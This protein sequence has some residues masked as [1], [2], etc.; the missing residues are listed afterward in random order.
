MPARSGGCWPTVSTAAIDTPW[1]R[2]SW[3]KYRKYS[4]PFGDTSLRTATR[5]YPFRFSQLTTRAAS[6][7]QSPFPRRKQYSPWKRSVPH[8]L[9]SG[10][11]RSLAYG[12]TTIALSEL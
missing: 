11:F 1:R 5:K 12:P 6:P 9:T 7:P 2:H 10:T 3:R 4:S 8:Q